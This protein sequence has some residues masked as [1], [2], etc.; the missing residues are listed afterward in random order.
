MD[1]VEEWEEDEEP[2]IAEDEPRGPS[3]ARRA[4]VAGGQRLR[5]SPRV[6]HVMWRICLLMAIVTAVAGVNVAG[7]DGVGSM[8]NGVIGIAPEMRATA[9]DNLN[10]RVDHRKDSAAITILPI[11]SEV[12]IRGLPEEGSG[13]EWWPVEFETQGETINGWVWEDGLDTTNVMRVIAIPGEVADTYRSASDGVSN[14]WDT[15]TGWLP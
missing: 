8:V 15:V 5:R 10:V 12:V 9:N 7:T 14:G 4:W 13:L 2:E 3:L 11:G 1:D 6:R